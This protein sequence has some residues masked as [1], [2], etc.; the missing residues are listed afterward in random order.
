M[1][2]QAAVLEEV[3]KFGENIKN[4]CHTR[5]RRLIPPGGG[6]RGGPPGWPAH[7]QQYIKDTLWLRELNTS[8]EALGGGGPLG[9]PPGGGPVMARNMSIPHFSS[10][11]G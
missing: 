4:I 7:K 11:I 2:L 6:P 8:G 3:L 1:A 5:R 10:M 9:G